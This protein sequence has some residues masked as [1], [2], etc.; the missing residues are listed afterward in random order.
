MERLATRVVG[1]WC[2]ILMLPVFIAGGVLMAASGASDL[3]PGTGDGGHEWLAAVA[4]D[5]R[6]LAGGWLVI[7]MGFL[8]VVAFVGFYD[9]L[10]TAGEA[11]IVAP[12]LG[13]AGLV[14]VQVSHLIPMGMASQ[15]A[16]AYAEQAADRPT[17]AA[18]SDTFAG[19]SLVVNSAG[20]ALVWG[21]AVP[22]YAW[23]VLATGA[24]PRWVGWLGLLVALCGG[25]VG[26]LSPLSGVAEGISSIGF[27]GFFI[28][29]VSMGIALLR[30]R[31][32]PDL[33]HPVG[34][35]PA[36]VPL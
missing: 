19:V 28:F 31:R 21:V 13:V 14:L 30:G 36:P 11:L 12:I 2:A 32:R 4:S 34:R 23:A 9:A 7:L 8:A 6:F 29:M 16:P 10:R 22:L 3:I 17:L 15:L 24:A 26:L 18:V 27:V 25:W 33:P 1:A 5:G 20:D 35:D